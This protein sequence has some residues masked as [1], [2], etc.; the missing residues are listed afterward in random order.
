MPINDIHDLVNFFLE[1][2]D[3]KD[4][5]MGAMSLFKFVLYFNKFLVKKILLSHEAFKVIFSHKNL[6]FGSTVF[7][8]N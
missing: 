7:R 5:G 3:Q 1:V 2:L 8:V 6:F 4:V